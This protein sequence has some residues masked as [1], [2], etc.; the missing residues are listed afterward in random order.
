LQF[1]GSF[2][3]TFF[4]QKISIF[5][6]IFR[7]KIVS[8]GSGTEPRF[9]ANHFRIDCSESVSQTDMYGLLAY[10]KK[11]EVGCRLLWHQG[12]QF[13]RLFAYWVVVYF[14]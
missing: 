14:G 10:V 11:E 7:G 5:P 1:L 13:G 12:D 2:F 6:N 4:P 8:P 3:K 9:F